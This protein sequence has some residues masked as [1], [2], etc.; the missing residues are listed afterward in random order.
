MYDVI[1]ASHRPFL[2]PHV[3]LFPQLFPNTLHTYTHMYR[4]QYNPQKTNQRLVEHKYG[5]WSLFLSWG[6]MRHTLKFANN[7]AGRSLWIQLRIWWFHHFT[8]SPWRC[9]LRHTFANEPSVGADGGGG[10]QLWAAI[11]EYEHASAP[12]WILLLRSK[13]PH[14][15][16]P[17]EDDRSQVSRNR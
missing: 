6:S 12:H 4:I 2:A 11:Y 1:S 13:T 14:Q 10:F 5:T 7:P 8:H 3:C 15:Y 16:D 17:P 9:H